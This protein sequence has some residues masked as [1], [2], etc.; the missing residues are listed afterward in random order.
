[1]KIEFDT[2]SDSLEHLTLLKDLIG[3]LVCQ[4]EEELAPLPELSAPAVFESAT[5]PLAGLRATVA[6]SFIPGDLS[7]NAPSVADAA[8]PVTV[9]AAPPVSA[10][11]PP[12]DASDPAQEP[13]V[14]SAPAAPTTSAGS[15]DRDTHGLPWDE[16]IHSSSRAKNADGSWRQ[17]RNLS[18]VTLEAVTTELRNRA[19]GA[20]SQA[21]VIPPPPVDVPQPPASAAAAAAP[22]LTYQQL[23]EWMTPQIMSA[24][25]TLDR[26]GEVVKSHGMT[27]MQDMLHK[28]EHADKIALVYRDLGGQ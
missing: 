28:P 9:P 25:L 7:G 17:R 3:G 14:P 20:P 18:P 24:A 26:V 1:M 13:S 15:D 10:P 23:M 12:T 2:V 6:E 5:D 11:P 27:S 4:R 8:A 19:A 16:R 21:A 22:G